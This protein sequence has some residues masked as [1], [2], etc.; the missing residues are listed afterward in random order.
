MFFFSTK[1]IFLYQ[2]ELEKGLTQNACLYQD[3]HENKTNDYFKIRQTFL[4]LEAGLKGEEEQQSTVQ[5]HTKDG[6]GQVDP[7]NG[8]VTKVTLSLTEDAHS[9][10]N[11]D[12]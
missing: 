11:I 5:N 9:Y 10:P 8:E 7:E 2:K 4:S 1:D 6:K 12:I 3:F